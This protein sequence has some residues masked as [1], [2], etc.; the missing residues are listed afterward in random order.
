MKRE[1]NLVSPQARNER[2]ELITLR[3]ERAI[4]AGIFLAFGIVA[5]SYGAIW[6][7]FYSLEQSLSDQIVLQSQDQSELEAGIR[8]LNREIGLVDSKI[9]GY[10]LW[11]ERI[12]EVIAVVPDGITLL[13]FALVENPETLV[14]TGNASDG[15]EVVAYQDALEQLPWVDRVIAPLQNFARFPSATVTFTIFQ[16]SEELPPL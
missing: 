1:I 11:T 4:A 14:V 8:S 16:K 10:T 6:W 12:A 13:Q 5:A 9:A 7:T 2:L 15:S 3:R